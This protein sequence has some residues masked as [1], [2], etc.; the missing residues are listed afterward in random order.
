M[1]C[2]YIGI[3]AHADGSP[4]EG[5]EHYYYYYLFPLIIYAHWISTETL[6]QAWDFVLASVYLCSFSVNQRSCYFTKL[7][8]NK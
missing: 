1:S 5:I 6:V 3:Y 7:K 2:V 4:S 8:F